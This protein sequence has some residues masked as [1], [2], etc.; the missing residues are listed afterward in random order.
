MWTENG[1]TTAPLFAGL[2]QTKAAAV[3]TADLAGKAGFAVVFFLPRELLRNVYF[4]VKSGPGD[5]GHGI[6]PQMKLI[7]SN[8]S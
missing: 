4:S 1:R 8:H 7:Y 5:K 6:N 3:I 2:F